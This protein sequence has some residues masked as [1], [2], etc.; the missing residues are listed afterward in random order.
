MIGEAQIAMMKPTVR[1]INVARGGLI[2]ETALANA[3]K[4]NRI[5]GAA[6]DVFSTEPATA[7]NPLLGLANIVHT[8]HLGASTEEAQVNVAIDI[9]EQIVDVLNGRPARAAV[10]MP[11]LGADVL[12]RIQPYLHLAEK[13][14]SLHAQLDRGRIDKVE[15][16]YSGDFADLPT[17]HITRGV[18]KGLLDPLLPDSV[19]YVNA[20]T[21]AARRNIQVIESYRAP[22]DDHSCLLTVRAHTDKE[23]REICGTVIGHGEVRI[24]HIDGFRVDI[25]PVGNMIVTEHTDRPG[26]IGKVGTLLGDKGINIAGMNVGRESIGHGALMVLLIDEP[27]PDA[28]HG[29]DR[30]NRRYGAG[31]SGTAM[32]VP[33]RVAEWPPSI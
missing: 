19:N 17:V 2:D 26:I 20:P 25:D 15:V 4:E 24:V 31:S 33:V 13:I 3:L 29:P 8:P 6:I 27:V 9:A 18:L 16:V 28:D 5:A 1:L 7:D 14:G 11:S 12:G 23:N 30:E 21:L 22:S 10:N 32:K